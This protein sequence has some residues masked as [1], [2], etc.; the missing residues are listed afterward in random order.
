MSLVYNVL[1]T[2]VCIFSFVL[3]SNDVMKCLLPDLFLDTS[4]PNVSQTDFTDLKAKLANNSIMSNIRRILIHQIS[5]REKQ[6]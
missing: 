4:K 5:P 2:I 3:C 1:I 6:L